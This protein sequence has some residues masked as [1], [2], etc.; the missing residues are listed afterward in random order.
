MLAVHPVSG[1][2]TV[3]RAILFSL[4]VALA[5]VAALLWRSARLGH[6]G[7]TFALFVLFAVGVAV[8]RALPLRK[9]ARELRR[10]AGQ[11][12]DATPHELVPVRLAELTHL[13][14]R[15]FDESAREL[16]ALGWVHL[17]DLVD[18]TLTASR[19]VDPRFGER[20][21]VCLRAFRSATGE[22]TAVIA[23]VG[24]AEDGRKL[25][26][27]STVFTDGRELLTN[28]A[29]AS[30]FDAPPHRRMQILPASTPTE[31]LTMV[32]AQAAG[33]MAQSFGVE[34]RRVMDVD[35]F[36]AEYNASI[37][38][39]ALFRASRG[40]VKLAELERVA[41]PERRE[42]LHQVLSFM[43]VDGDTVRPPEHD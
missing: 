41:G 11:L 25:L 16:M 2:V 40:G 30:G 21:P 9:A 10:V 35:A 19:P 24:S 23:Q 31:E 39:A 6:V 37:A 26:E 43:H 12:T 7:A 18:R 20:L 3:M 5:V 28:R 38:R 33:E 34:P 4:W 8:T 22:D 36:V 14:R 42:V 13:D 17:G 29:A 27:C 1:Y 32:H 15:F